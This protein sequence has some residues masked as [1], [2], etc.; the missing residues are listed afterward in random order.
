MRVSSLAWILFFIPLAAPKAYAFE[1]DLK[2]TLSS[3]ISTFT[4]SGKG[5]QEDP[6]ATAD[7]KPDLALTF[8]DSIQAVIAPHFRLGLTDPEYH[9]VSPDE[10]FIDYVKERFEIRAGYQIHFWG[11]VESSNIVDILN[12]KDF[13][14]DF[15]DPEK[16]G[17]PSLRT[18]FLLGESRFDFYLFPTFTPAELPGPIN[19][20]SFFDGALD[21]S[22]DPLYTHPAKDRRLQG[23]LRWDYTI[24]S[25]DIGLSYF[26]GYEKFPIINLTPGES[27]ANT[28]YYEMQQ[29]GG[30][31]QMSLGEWLIKAEAIYQDTG[32]AGSFR[33]NS[34]LPSGVFLPLRELVPDNHTALVGGLEYTFFG[35]LGTGDLGVI[36]EYLYD[37]EQAPDAVAF[38]PFQNDFFGG[39][40]WTR[41][42]PGDAE[43]LAGL[44]LDLKEQSMI[45]SVEYSERYFDR[46][47]LI[48]SLDRINAAPEDPI[49]VF[50]ND[51]RFSLELSY[52]Y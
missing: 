50:N 37:S 29:A 20:F 49:S 13:K 6:V 35:F 2:V 52:T 14:G 10:L 17:E 27:K 26:N 7:I 3:K 16:L 51:D 4:Q 38:R 33:R 8:S 15:L 48:A 28:V 23:A 45:L 1:T 25:A 24:G 22:D 40:R 44:I 12:Q 18:R 11:T 31:L 42:N 36:A 9:L 32:L 34:I 5:D 39:F 41:N 19:R 47:K 46:I 43:L 30:D 21:F